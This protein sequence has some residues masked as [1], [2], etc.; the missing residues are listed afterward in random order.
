MASLPL[1]ER[2]LTES[3][4]LQLTRLIERTRRA[5]A[6]Q[7]MPLRGLLDIADLV[8]EAE[9]PPDEVSMQS[10]V[11]LMAAAA[12]STLTLCPPTDANAATGH[13]S[14]N[15]PVGCSLPGLRAGCAAR[16]RTPDGATTPAEIAEVLFQPE[17]P[18]ARRDALPA[19]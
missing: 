4:P 14:V 1:G 9:V 7:A 8:R 3:D 2:V 5:P 10:R 6:P 16:W 17:S 11:L 18:R 19:D 12:P 13:V 15:S